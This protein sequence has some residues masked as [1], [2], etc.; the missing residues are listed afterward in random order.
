MLM[1]LSVVIILYWI[2]YGLNYLLPS[3]RCYLEL[4][5]KMANTHFNIGN[6]LN[7]WK[8]HHMSYGMVSRNFE[9]CDN[10]KL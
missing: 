8:Q 2:L 1:C 10:S 5:I 7:S 3:Y 9:L 4:S 6:H